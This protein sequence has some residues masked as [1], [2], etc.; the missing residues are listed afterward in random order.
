MWKTCRL[1]IVECVLGLRRARKGYVKGTECLRLSSY[2]LLIIVSSFVSV[3]HSFYVSCLVL[4][5]LVS[6]S[7]FLFTALR[8]NNFVCSPSSFPQCLLSFITY[9]GI[10]FLT[11]KTPPH[12]HTRICV[13]F[14]RS[15]CVVADVQSVAQGVLPNVCIGRT[16][17]SR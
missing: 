4:V 7:A 17:G 6:Y 10:W 12:T 5:T 14:S 15:P 8:V 2:G 16:D 9:P 3:C 11:N 1:V 13:C